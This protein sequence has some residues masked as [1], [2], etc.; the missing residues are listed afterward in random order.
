M[1]DVNG[2]PY[3]QMVTAMQLMHNVVADEVGD[4]GPI[5]DSWATGT[6]GVSCTANMPESTASPLAIVTTSCRL[7]PS[8][9]VTFSEGSMPPGG[10]Q[11][12]PT[13]DG[14]FPP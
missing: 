10:H 4:N 9:A 2:N 5:C 3:P 6:S 1:I 11:A 8:A 13:P 7:A 12:I 14:G